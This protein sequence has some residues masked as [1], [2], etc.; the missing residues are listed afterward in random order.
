VLAVD[1]HS[2]QQDTSFQ[3]YLWFLIEA[4]KTTQADLK[5]D[6][7]VVTAAANAATILNAVRIPF[8][9]RNLKGIRIPS[10]DLSYGRL[11]S[12][13][14]QDSDCQN[15]AFQSA[16]LANVNFTRAKMQGQ[17]WGMAIYKIK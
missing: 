11:D 14:L 17:A 4:S 9:G 12:A 8:S 7:E 5:K 15:V 16:W 3:D 6:K 10:A 1:S 2:L 13:D